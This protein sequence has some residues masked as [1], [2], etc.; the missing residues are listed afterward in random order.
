MSQAIIIADKEIVQALKDFADLQE[1][2]LLEFEKQ[3]HPLISFDSFIEKPKTGTLKALKEEWKF[4]KH[5]AGILFEE[6]NSGTKVN[7]HREAINHKRAFDSWRLY[8]YFE[9][10]KCFEIIWQSDS[11]IAND[12]DDLDKLLGELDQ[13]KIIKTVSQRKNLYELT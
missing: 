1:Q 3:C 2:L 12:D 9:S 8:D 13:A 6:I 4:Q 11:Y 5:G 10:I 7:V